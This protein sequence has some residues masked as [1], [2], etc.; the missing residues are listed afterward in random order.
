[1]ENLTQKYE[2]LSRALVSLRE[3]V[4][5]FNDFE[6]TD[7]IKFDKLD[8]DK[9]Y[10]VFRDSLIQRF[11]YTTD[12]FWKYLKTYLEYKSLLTNIIGPAIVVQEACYL[13][14][15]TELEG[16][17]LLIMIK[18]RNKTSHMYIEEVAEQ[19]AGKI[20]SYCDIMQ[21]IIKRLVP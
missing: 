7:K 3:A 12:I 9:Y 21:L 10:R 5:N 1:M 2:N 4:E 17:Q 20:P 19:L 16:H 13:G 15:L 18:G 11:E 8:Y 14:L 6:T